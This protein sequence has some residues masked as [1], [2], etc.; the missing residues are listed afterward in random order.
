MAKWR[1]LGVCR[2]SHGAFLRVGAGLYTA[3]EQE[4][5]RAEAEREKAEAAAMSAE[6]EEEKE[7]AR[8]AGMLADPV[9][10]PVASGLPEVS[11]CQQNN[12]S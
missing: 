5:K 8:D 4:Q 6:I 12:V 10:D 1:T 2:P 3:E 11:E 7:K 9:I